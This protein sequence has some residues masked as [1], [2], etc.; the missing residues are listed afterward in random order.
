MGAA[1]NVTDTME[2]INNV[3]VRVSALDEIQW[4]V[5]LSSGSVP[6]SWQREQ[7]SG[8]GGSFPQTTPYSWRSRFPPTSPPGNTPPPLPLRFRPFPDL[9]FYLALHCMGYLIPSA[10]PANEIPS[11]GLLVDIPPIL[12]SQGAP[13]LRLHSMM[14][15]SVISLPVGKEFKVP[16]G[17]FR[18]QN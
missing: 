9:I 14:N 16:F 6:C 12:F 10:F 7:K 2:S 18:L 11:L 3:S 17:A 15:I 8:M 1:D 4:F 13:F 5:L